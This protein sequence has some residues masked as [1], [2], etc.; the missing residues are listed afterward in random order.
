MHPP[1]Q[2]VARSRP[3]CP[4]FPHSG[5]LNASWVVVQSGVV[6][7]DVVVS[8]SCGYEKQYF[9]THLDVIKVANDYVSLFT[10]HKHS[11]LASVLHAFIV[12]E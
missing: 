4:F 10:T 8:L 11:G 9:H 3:E 12:S 5:V 7:Q 2:L 1:F 6:A